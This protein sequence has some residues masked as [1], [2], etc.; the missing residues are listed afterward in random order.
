MVRRAIESPYEH[1]SLP[2]TPALARAGHDIRRRSR[3][4]CTDKTCLAHSNNRRRRRGEAGYWRPGLAQTRSEGSAWSRSQPERKT[5]PTPFLHRVV[6]ETSN[7]NTTK[8]GRFH[9]I[10]KVSASSPSQVSV[11]N[12]R[13]SARTTVLNCPDSSPSVFS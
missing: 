8:A 13:R 11:M 5:P 6:A 10:R 12:R 4:P 1:T 2:K 9:V 7:R 3:N